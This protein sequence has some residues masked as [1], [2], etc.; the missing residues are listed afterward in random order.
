LIAL[1]EVRIPPR[2][3]AISRFTPRREPRQRRSRLLVRKI[4]DASR[5]ILIQEGPEALTTNQVAERAN[6][7]VGS[8]YQYFPNKSA[9]VAVLVDELIASIEQ[10]TLAMLLQSPEGETVHERSRRVI[11]GFVRSLLSKAEML[12]ALLP[13]VAELQALGLIQRPEDRIVETVRSYNRDLG[14]EV[15]HLDA[16]VAMNMAVDCISH[17]VGQYI[18]RNRPAIGGDAFADLLTDLATSFLYGDAAG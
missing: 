9:I 6:V 10:E 8:V 7:S 3:P 16:D 17:L 11:H 14:I 13:Y 5:D 12:R 18:V 2:N 15:R 4:L 1:E